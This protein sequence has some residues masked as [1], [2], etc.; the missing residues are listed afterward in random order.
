MA[1]LHLIPL[2]LLLQMWTVCDAQNVK[3]EPFV[4]GFVGQQ[5]TLRCQIVDPD[6][7]LQITQVT[8]MK[9]PTTSKINLAVYNPDYGINYPTDTG[10]RIR[11]R[12]VNNRDATLIIDRLEM[13]DDGIYSCEF[14]TYPDGNQDAT[15]NLTILAKPVNIG[16]AIPAKAG[17]TEVPVAMCVSLAGK[18]PASI[19][20]SEGSGNISE[21]VIAHGNGTF[22]VKSEY[23]L[24]PSG[25]N[26]G[27]QLTCVIRQK[28]LEQP[29]TIP[30]I[31]SVQYAPIV[32]I[33]GYD[34]NWYQGREHASLTCTAKANPQAS[35]YKWLM[36]G[37]R[38]PS[39]VQVDGHQ[40]TVKDVDYSV[41]GTFT[42]EA[43][44]NLGTGRAKMDIVVRETPMESGST[45]GAIVGGI[46]AAIVILTVLVTAVLIFKRQRKN[47][48]A[49]EDDF[50]PPNYK[51]PPPK[52][53]LDETEKV[54]KTEDE[55][56][57]SIPINTTYF[58]TGTEDDNRMYYN[59]PEMITNLK[60]ANVAVPPGDYLEQENPIYN[61]FSYTEPEEHRKSQEFVSKGMYV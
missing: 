58:E 49:D 37:Q 46:I 1:T 12:Q 19:T 42:C 4:Y 13:A 7:T 30:I 36:N 61:D 39:T 55:E 17:H 20:W 32:I 21:T 23:M 15:T 5:A 27:E 45:T 29:Q 34:E 56:M 8:W 38:L 59:E 44:N 16:K 6:S 14:A 26:N 9:D 3:V 31:L 60:S 50:E 25:E 33:E 41:N 47:T 40:L 2:A 43:T 35:N 24:I 28:A 10:G 53:N 51:P 18:P 22:T 48:D 54:L 11:F 57:E 52:K